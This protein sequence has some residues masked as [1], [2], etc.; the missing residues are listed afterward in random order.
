MLAER[1]MP[2]A[3][4][5]ALGSCATPGF[6]PAGAIF[7]DVST[8]VYGTSPTGSKKGEACVK[9]YLGLI[10]LGDGSVEAAAQ[11]GGITKINNINLNGWNLLIYAQLC[12][13]VQGD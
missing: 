13:V 7:G 10:A 12:T 5:F 3:A 4:L 1:L 6:G 8:G 9:S 11:A 2:L